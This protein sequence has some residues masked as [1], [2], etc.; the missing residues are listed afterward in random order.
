MDRLDRMTQHNWRDHWRCQLQ[1]QE[2]VLCTLEDYFEGPAEKFKRFQ[3][4]QSSIVGPAAPAAAAAGPACY[5][6]A[7][8]CVPSS[9][10][11]DVRLLSRE[12]TVLA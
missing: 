3:H 9:F 4:P 2:S 5:Y 8:L 1:K 12:L 11:A 7:S 6:A 10:L